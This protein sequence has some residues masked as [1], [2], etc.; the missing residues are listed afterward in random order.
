MVLSAFGWL[1]I[2]WGYCN[3]DTQLARRNGDQKQFAQRLVKQALGLCIEQGKTRNH[4]DKPA[5]HDGGTWPY[6]RAMF[7][8]QKHNPD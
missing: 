1:E 8:C 4:A 5:I 3:G 2:F 6:S 7:S